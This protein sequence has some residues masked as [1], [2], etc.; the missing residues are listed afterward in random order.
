[1]TERERECVTEAVVDVRNIHHLGRVDYEE[2]A[3]GHMRILPYANLYILP[4]I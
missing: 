1:M 3:I 4:Y 2:V